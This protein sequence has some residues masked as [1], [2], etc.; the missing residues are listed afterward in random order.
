MIL[1][2]IPVHRLPSTATEP[3]QVPSHRIAF[4][5]HLRIGVFSA[6]AASHRNT[7]HTLTKGSTYPHHSLD[8]DFIFGWLSSNLNLNLKLQKLQTQAQV[9]APTWD[10]WGTS[11]T[12]RL[13]ML[14]TYCAPCHSPF[15]HGLVL[16][17]IVLFLTITLIL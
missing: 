12:R 15:D 3:Q 13:G 11:R 14:R 8:P 16:G 4:S 17:C 2:W 7:Q 5:A 9:K 1:S 6:T 10:V